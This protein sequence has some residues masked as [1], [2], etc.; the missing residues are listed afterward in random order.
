MR[1]FGSVAVIGTGLLVAGFGMAPAPP[2]PPTAMVEY[3]GFLEAALAHAQSQLALAQMVEQKSKTAA[4]VA[5][6]KRVAAQRSALVDQLNAA[7]QATGA[8]ADFGHTPNLDTF[9]PLTG[10][11][12][13]RAYIAAELED[14]QNA[15]DEY[16]FASDHITAPELKDLAATQV[17]QLEQDIADA[18]II[19]RGLPFGDAEKDTSSM[20]ISPRQR[21]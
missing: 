12:F 19:V 4:L 21:R 6:A 2:D 16:Q 11:E 8:M 1:W 10:E 7:A 3:N 5:Y 18:Q 20:V 9:K 17:P 14:E 13:E 15:L